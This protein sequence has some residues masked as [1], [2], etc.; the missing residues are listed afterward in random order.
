[1]ARFLDTPGKARALRDTAYAV[2]L[3]YGISIPIGTALFIYRTEIWG[4]NAALTGIQAVCL[5]AGLVLSAILRRALTLALLGAATVVLGGLVLAGI[6]LSG[7]GGAPFAV[8]V[9]VVFALHW[10]LSLIFPAWWF[11]RGR[12]RFVSPTSDQ[13]R[14]E[15]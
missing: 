5:F 1:M 9:V 10:L 12:R 6:A 13:R 15:A 11:L 8:V 2:Y 4:V 14:P 3:T 7:A